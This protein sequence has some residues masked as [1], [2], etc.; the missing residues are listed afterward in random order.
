MPRGP[1][2]E[3]RPADVIGNAVKVTRIATG[4]ETEELEINCE[5]SAGAELGERVG[6]RG[7]RALTVRLPTAVRPVVSGSYMSSTTTAGYAYTPG[8]TARTR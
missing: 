7:Y 6:A 2:G 3:K 8:V 4:E 5:K 1:R